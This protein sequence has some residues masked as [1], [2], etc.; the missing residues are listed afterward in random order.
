MN[1]Q[2]VVRYKKITTLSCVYQIQKKTEIFNIFFRKK[3]G[4]NSKI[5][6]E[7][8]I[9]KRRNKLFILKKNRL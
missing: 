4:P 7:S 1:I 8:S 2:L 5:Q 9:C 3:S 6:N